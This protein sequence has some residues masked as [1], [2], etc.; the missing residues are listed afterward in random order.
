M[1]TRPG[2]RLVLLASLLAASACVT[3]RERSR[4]L[5]APRLGSISP[6]LVIAGRPF[7]V[8]PD[9]SSVLSF[10]GENLYQGSRARLNGEPLETSGG[11]DKRSLAAIVPRRLTAAPGVYTVTVEHADGTP[12]NGLPLTV[13]SV[14]GPAPSIGA[15][16]PD[17]TR[18]GEIFN[19]QPDGAA[20]AVTGAGFR[21]GVVVWFGGVRLRTF[22]GG[23]DRLSALVPAGLIARAGDV[24][25]V[26]ENPDG[27]R[28]A[29]ARFQIL[30]AAGAG[31]GPRK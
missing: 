14:T 9:G 10:T 13:L 11:L 8:Q 24:E 19:P 30:G 27:K 29:P 7:N 16:H 26:I 31:A 23:T 5:P 25:V 4:P 2:A 1:V 15:L 3:E 28:S 21:P 20:F 12:S 18:A 6:E 22:L 17:S